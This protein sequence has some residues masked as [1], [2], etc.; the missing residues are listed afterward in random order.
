[1]NTERAKELVGKFRGKKVLVVGDAVIDHYVYGVVERLNPEAPVPI[2]EAQKEVEHTGGAGNVAKNLA[3]LGADTVFVGLVGA[4]QGADRYAELAKAEGYRAVCI[5]DLDRPTTR[6][7]RHLVRSQQ[8]LRVDYEKRQDASP[9]VE[10]ELVAAI[11]DEIERGVNAVLVS[12]YAKGVITPASAKA[13]IARAAKYKVPVAADIKPAHASLF[14]GVDFISPNL[15]E[16]HEMLGINHHES[17]LPAA[18]L[19]A[20]LK[21]KMKC[22][23]FVTLG[24]DGMC[25]ATRDS[26]SEHVPQEHTVEVFD[27]SGAGDT[28][29]SVLLLA[30]LAG[31]SVIEA[32][33]LANAAGAVVVGKIGSVGVSPEEVI[34]MLAHQHE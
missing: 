2:L 11:A 27:V 3:K 24:P 26:V 17:D 33:E 15:K 1:M 28:A 4:D 34:N 32:A 8:L 5:R 9:Q 31:A 20:R 7:V 16:A 10:E 13:I 18:D 12:D 21:D 14:I 22:D 6:K 23:V 30:R 25:A 29:I 19:A